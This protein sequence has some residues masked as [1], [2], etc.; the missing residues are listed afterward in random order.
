VRVI[1]PTSARAIVKHRGRELSDLFVHEEKIKPNRTGTRDE[2]DSRLTVA[3][4]VHPQLSAADGYMVPNS[5]IRRL[6]H[7]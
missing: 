1:T 6:S 7:K 3:R 2:H 4:V 5:K